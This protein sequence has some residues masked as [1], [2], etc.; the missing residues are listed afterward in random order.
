MSIER[1]RPQ[2]FAPLRINSNELNSFFSQVRDRK[3]SRGDSE[4]SLRRVSHKQFK[5]N[6]TAFEE[7][8]K[9]QKA[10]KRVTKKSKN[11]T[12]TDTKKKIKKKK[13]SKVSS[14]IKKKRLE[15]KLQ[16][17]RF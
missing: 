10:K 14:Q 3:L 8:T 4:D 11:H 12:V 2:T 9:I 6:P 16:T 1:T 15:S 7:T 13:N 5:N 17:D